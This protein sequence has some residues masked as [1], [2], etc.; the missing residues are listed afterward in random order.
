MSRFRSAW[1]SDAQ[2]LNRDRRYCS[3]L[4]RPLRNT[5]CNCYEQHLLY[6]CQNPPRL[7]DPRVVTGVGQGL[8][9]GRMRLDRGADV[10]LVAVA[11]RRRRVTGLFLLGR[12]QRDDVAGC[13]RVRLE[14]LA[15]SGVLS[16]MA[17]AYP[18][19][20]SSG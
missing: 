19:S 4:K 9:R 1:R 2:P 5:S 11:E 6:R 17:R 13:D 18:L 20:G 10:E 3:G 7:D 16:A 14:L 12:D 8:R 15:G